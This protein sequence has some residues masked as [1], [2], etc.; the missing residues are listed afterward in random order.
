ML[1]PTT[2][3]TTIIPN[4]CF[5]TI[6]L[7]PQSSQIY[8]Y[9]RTACRVGMMVPIFAAVCLVIPYECINIYTYIYACIYL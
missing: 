3:P 9:Q 6:H 7:K 5:R 4:L 8:E 1:S 2:T